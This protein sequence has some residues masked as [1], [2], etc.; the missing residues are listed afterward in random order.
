MNGVGD[1]CRFCRT[2]GECGSGKICGQ[3]GQCVDCLTSAQ[4]GDRVCNAGT[5]E[6]CISSTQ[7]SGDQKCN[8]LTGRCTDCVGDSDCG[9]SSAC[10][11]GECYQQCTDNSQCPDQYCGN[12]ACVD[13]TENAHCTPSEFC[14]FGRC[15]PQCTT[16]GDCIGGRVCDV[17][18][19]TC[20]VPCSQS[21]PL[22][23]ACNAAQVCSEVCGS[24]SQCGLHEKCDSTGFC[25]PEC[26]TTPDCTATDPFSACQGGQCVPSGPCSV[27]AQCSANQLCNGGSCQN[28]PPG[29]TCTSACDC[30]Q[31]EI[32][33]TGAC[34]VDTGMAPTKFLATGATGNGSSVL[35]P[36][37]SLATV[38]SGV[39][40]GDVIAV[41]GDDTI[42]IT[43]RVT[44]NSGGRKM[45]GGFVQCASN[46]WVRDPTKRSTLNNSSATGVGVLR[47]LDFG[48]SKFSGTEDVSVTRTG[49]IMGS[50]MYMSPEQ[51]KGSKLV[52]TPTDLYAIGVILYE[53]LGGRPP[54][55][56]DSYNELIVNLITEQHEPLSKVRP[57]VPAALGAVVDRLLAK[58]PAA[59]PATASET[60][61][62]LLLALGQDSTDVDLPPAGKHVATFNP[63]AATMAA[64]A[65]TTSPSGQNLATVPSTEPPAAVQ[66]RRRASGLIIGALI[67]AGV[68]VGGAA[69]ITRDPKPTSSNAAVSPPPATTAPPER[70]APT[71]S[72]T[73]AN[74]PA[75]SGG[76][77]ATPA[78]ATTSAG[79]PPPPTPQGSAD[80]HATTAQPP[81]DT[82][83]TTRR[84]RPPADQT[85]TKPADG[86]LTIDKS[87]P[88]P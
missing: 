61:S 44:V 75:G 71:P 43:T 79:T 70:A 11:Q 26:T 23:E 6:S 63:L 15:R 51:A 19:N 39:Q 20:V 9:P 68:M 88:Y 80:V 64:T 22:G 55:R 38:L 40:S 49:S 37:G 50:P 58:D 7:C 78:T 77:A 66:H 36:S 48:I 32:C 31:G 82:S 46:R 2:N 12:G 34:V 56:G 67:A 53:G 8:W 30:R 10:I 86:T 72:A 57:D 69:W 45:V 18:T 28:R 1:A 27:D 74:A 17:A 14:D 52:G 33:Q 21:C 29:M 73:A 24:S 41:R 83:T 54:F 47:I 62:A 76:T 84:R 35:T 65:E 42:D 25:A 59:R 81:K 16:D 87:N 3:F 60:R 4:C 85:T 5:C 13:C